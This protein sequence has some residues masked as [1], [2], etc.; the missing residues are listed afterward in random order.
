[1]LRARLIAFLKDTKFAKFHDI[2]KIP[3]KACF[4]GE[5]LRPYPLSQFVV[6]FA[7][8]PFPF[9]KITFL[10]LK[11]IRYL[12]TQTDISLQRQLTSDLKVFVVDS[13][14]EHKLRLNSSSCSFKSCQQRGVRKF[15]QRLFPVSIIYC[16]KTFQD[17][18]DF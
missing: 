15:A 17:N 4:L 16:L 13:F 12:L 3:L 7:P 14:S 1:M 6:I 11:Y 18:T 2:M 10:N 8:K 9:L 5:P